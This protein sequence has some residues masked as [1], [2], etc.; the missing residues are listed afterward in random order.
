MH[1][2]ESIILPSFQNKFRRVGCTQFFAYSPDPNHPSR[3]LLAAADVGDYTQRANYPSPEVKL[4]VDER[5][6]RY[7]VHALIAENKTPAVDKLL[8]DLHS[9]DPS[10][11]HTKDDVGIF[12]IS[13]A[14]GMSNLQAVKTLLS[15]GVT[16]DLFIR[17]PSTGQTPLESCRAKLDSDRQFMDTFGLWKGHDETDLLIEV[18]LK[19]AMG[20]PVNLTDEE[21]VQKMKYGC[22]CGSCAE[23][24]LS[25]RMRFRLHCGSCWLQIPA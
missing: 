16:E 18:N 1:G 17:V 19:R 10:C 4:T 5:L 23:G 25:L 13:I 8:R 20:M 7:P 12:P 15:L 14:A 24:W 3:N 2:W 21:Y 9:V 22:T 6:E 11:I